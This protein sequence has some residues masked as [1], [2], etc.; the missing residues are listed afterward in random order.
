M[1]EDPVGALSRVALACLPTP[2][3]AAP[4]L[5][6]ELGIEVLLKR[7]DLTGL[8]LGGNK[9]R[10][11]ELLLGDGLERGCDV[12]VTGSGPQSNW[13][14]LA[15]LAAQRC[16]MD[17]VLC[18]YGDPPA[19]ALGNMLLHAFTGA[20]LTWTGSK[21]RSSVDTL[22][23]ETATRLR[24]AGRRPLELPR[25]GATPRGSVGYLIGAREIAS[26][27]RDLGH[28]A[29]TVW[30]ATGSCGTQAGLVLGVAAGELA[31]VRGVTVSR[32]VKECTRRV[33]DLA[34]GA[35]D[36]LGS[37]HPSP[38]AVDVL[39][40][41]IGPGYGVESGAGRKAAELVARTEG[42]LLDPVFGAKAMAALVDAA[43][44][45]TVV[46][47]VVFLV[48]GGAPT[49]FAVGGDL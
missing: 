22:I 27:M 35:A 11:L 39:D 42:V 15:A 3:H 12:V 37:P 23:A 33:H 31:E 45:G 36:L 10:S 2:L 5:S 32:P 9:A 13:A 4:R 34:S 18:F 43:G 17:S 16:G 49:L 24:A 41:W 28:T 30:L 26:Q 8:G 6:A 29:P 14:M 48:T 19:T 38:D 20:T 47:S 21:E 7:D 25:G 40:G 1:A 44:H 46:G